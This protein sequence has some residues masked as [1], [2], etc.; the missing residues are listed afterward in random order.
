M[1]I[2]IVGPLANNHL[3]HLDNLKNDDV[4]CEQPLVSFDSHLV[5]IGTA[6]SDFRVHASPQAWLADSQQPLR[7][8]D[9]NTIFYPY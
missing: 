5:D 6:K 1:T 3:D 8:Q 7:L 9:K 2:W 4:I